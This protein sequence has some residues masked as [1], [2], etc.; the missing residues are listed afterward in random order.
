MQTTSTI[1]ALPV[2]VCIYKRIKKFDIV[3]IIGGPF[4]DTIGTV[5]EIYHG[6]G[7]Y[8]VKTPKH[9]LRLYRTNIELHD[10]L[11]ISDFVQVTV[12]GSFLGK[13]GLINNVDAEGIVKIVTFP[14]DVSLGLLSALPCII[15]VSHRGSFIFTLVTLNGRLKRRRFPRQRDILLSIDAFKSSRDP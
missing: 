3:R 10:Q 14:S 11:C 13:E 12:H 4:V 6:T 8:I 7:W 15:N 2:E 5:E 9:Y 1:F